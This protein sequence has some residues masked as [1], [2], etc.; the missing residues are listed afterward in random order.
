MLKIDVLL[1]KTC[2]SLIYVV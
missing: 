1:Y 2:I